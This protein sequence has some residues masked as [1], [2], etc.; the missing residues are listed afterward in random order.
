MTPVKPVE[1]VFFFWQPFPLW[2]RFLVDCTVPAGG[3]RNVFAR[4]FAMLPNL[5]VNWLIILLTTWDCA[6]FLQVGRLPIYC[7]FAKYSS[8]KVIKLAKLASRSV[9]IDYYKRKSRREIFK[10]TNNW[11][12][13]RTLR[14]VRSTLACHNRLSTHTKKKCKEQRN[15]ETNFFFP[16]HFLQTWDSSLSASVT[17]ERRWNTHDLVIAIL[18]DI[19]II[20]RSL[21]V[22]QSPW[23][24]IFFF[25]FFK[26]PRI[27]N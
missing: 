1:P 20:V 17:N 11:W 27:L 10:S 9:S 16:V 18:P 15:N 26:F 19:I 21:R 14:K 6:D 23:L 25:F 4:Y 2:P 5:L 8:E 3:L 7:Q 24:H 13:K 12:W 22:E